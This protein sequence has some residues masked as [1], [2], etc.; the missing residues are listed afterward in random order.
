MK[1]F[2]FVLMLLVEVGCLQAQA[3]FFWSD[4]FA[5]GDIS[6]VDT[7]FVRSWLGVTIWP[8]GCDINLQVSTAVSDTNWAAKPWILI[9][10]GSVLDIWPDYPIY[11]CAVRQIRFITPTASD[12]GA[13]FLSGIKST[14]QQ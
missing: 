1:K 6:I 13:V 2:L 8:I 11:S 5:V 10:D 7:V 12:T 4:S 9:P 14:V 3:T